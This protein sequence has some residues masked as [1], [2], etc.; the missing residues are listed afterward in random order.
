M[1]TMPVPQLLFRPRLAR[2]SAFTFALL[3]ATLPAQSHW[4]YPGPHGKL[5]YTYTTKGD[6]IPDFSYAGYGG[7]GVA[8]PTVRVF[9]V[10]EL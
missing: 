4:A 9:E 6:R 1:N 5:V 3:T 2:L 7:G 8:L 10:T